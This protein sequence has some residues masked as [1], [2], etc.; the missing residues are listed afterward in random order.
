MA[1][2]PELILS[3]DQTKT[4]VKCSEDIFNAETEYEKTLENSK[5]GDILNIMES[6]EGLLQQNFY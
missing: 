4:L 6:M 3:A 5:I 1:N 2:M